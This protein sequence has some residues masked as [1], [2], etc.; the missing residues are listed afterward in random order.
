MLA[1]IA[2]AV[3]NIIRGTMNHCCEG[4]YTP[5]QYSTPSAITMIMTVTIEVRNKNLIHIS[6]IALTEKRY[7]AYISAPLPLEV[8]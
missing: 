7:K 2:R 3:K 4:K 6:A 5:R 1:I 8:L